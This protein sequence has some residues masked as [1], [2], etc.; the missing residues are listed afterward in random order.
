MPCTIC[1]RC[2][3][4][5]EPST[6]CQGF[7]RCSIGVHGMRETTVT[8]TSAFR[9]TCDCTTGL[10]C[11]HKAKDY[12]EEPKEEVEVKRGAVAQHIEVLP[13]SGEAVRRSRMCS[14]PMIILR[15]YVG[16]AVR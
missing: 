15:W 11:T 12:E 14:R 10:D 8:Y 7:S 5:A 6:G 9:G 1:Q 4:H 3:D 16:E 13:D 2:M